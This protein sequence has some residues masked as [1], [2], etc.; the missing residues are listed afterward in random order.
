[1][2]LK[3]A[4]KSFWSGIVMLMK[5]FITHLSSAVVLTLFLCKVSERLLKIPYFGIHSDDLLSK[6][7]ISVRQLIP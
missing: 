2:S 4:I 7:L 5:H 3:H 1:M 6:F